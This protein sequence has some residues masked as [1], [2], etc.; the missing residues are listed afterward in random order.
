[1]VLSYKKTIHL[2]TRKVNDYFNVSIAL[3]IVLVVV[4][5]VVVIV[6][7]VVIVTLQTHQTITQ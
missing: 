3:R 5:V 6:I 4:V 2:T 7:V 1:M